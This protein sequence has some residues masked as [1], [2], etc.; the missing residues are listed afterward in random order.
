MGWAKGLS[1][2]LLHRYWRA[3]PPGSQYRTSL[4]SEGGRWEVRRR[5]TGGGV[6]DQ[7]LDILTVSHTCYRR[8]CVYLLRVLVYNIIPILL[9]LSITVTVCTSAPR[10]YDL[11]DVS[12]CHLCAPRGPC[13]LGVYL[14]LYP[15]CPGKVCVVF[16]KIRLTYNMLPFFPDSE[17]R[18]F[19]MLLMESRWQSTGLTPISARETQCPEDSGL[20]TTT[21]LFFHPFAFSIGRVDTTI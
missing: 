15:H 19:S 12:C 11:L 6:W 18:A 10:Y 21:L 5:E 9:F 1:T 7:G 17:P 4:I 20:S 13:A 16:L 3:Q 2:Y 14:S 8:L